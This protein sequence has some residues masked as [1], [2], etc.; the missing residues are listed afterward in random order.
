V[1]NIQSAVYT[2]AEVALLLNI[3]E[4]MVYERVKAGEIPGVRRFGTKIRFIK[5]A[6]NEWLGI[7]PGLGPIDERAS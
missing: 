2:V 5:A 3:S 7:D 1:S 4:W 6:V